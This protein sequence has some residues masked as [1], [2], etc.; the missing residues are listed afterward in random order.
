MKPSTSLAAPPVRYPLRRTDVSVF[1]TFGAG[2]GVA[3]C[4]LTGVSSGRVARGSIQLDTNA[5]IVPAAI[6]APAVLAGG[7]APFIF[8]YDRLLPNQTGTVYLDGIALGPS[9]TNATGFGSVLVPTTS[10]VGIHEVAWIGA[11]GQVVNPPCS[12]PL[13]SP[14][15]LRRTPP[16]TRRPILTRRRIQ[17]RT[18]RR[19]R[20]PTRQ[21]THQPTHR[22]APPPLAPS[23]SSPTAGSR[24]GHSR[25]GPWIAR[26]R[27]RSSPHRRR[28]S[29]PQRHLLRPC[30]QPARRRDPRR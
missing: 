24:R 27:P 14:P 11:S 18:L 9:N 20:Q 25:P 16:P 22:L 29:R 15:Q 23:I 6:N 1:L 13:P 8:Q 17:R 28:L 7:A 12:L 10:T 5:I 4:V 21:P 2:A 3:Q 19:T 26:P 30:G